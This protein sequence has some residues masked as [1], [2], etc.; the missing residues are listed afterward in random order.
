MLLRMTFLE[1][2]IEINK[3]LQKFIKSFLTNKC[4]RANQNITLA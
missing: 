2:G 4:I 1:K 3:S